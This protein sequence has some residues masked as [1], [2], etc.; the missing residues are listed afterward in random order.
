MIHAVMEDVGKIECYLSAK[1]RIP[2][3]CLFHGAKLSTWRSQP[4][5]SPSAIEYKSGEYRDGQ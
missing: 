3:S 1:A 4:N 5:K 2:R